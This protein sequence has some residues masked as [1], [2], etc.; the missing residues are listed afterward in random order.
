M[1]YVVHHNQDS[2]SIG[3]HEAKKYADAVGTVRTQ[4]EKTDEYIR[5]RKPSGGERKHPALE[6]D[7]GT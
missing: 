5:G 3:S 4:F 1:L 7:Y 6:A 2:S